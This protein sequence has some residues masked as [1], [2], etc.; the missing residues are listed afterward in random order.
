MT[1]LTAVMWWY[2]L[3]LAQSS[4]LASDGVVPE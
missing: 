1:A 3:G 2:G 4:N